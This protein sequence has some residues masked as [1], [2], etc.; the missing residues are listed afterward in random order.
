MSA[1]NLVLSIMGGLAGLAILG[2]GMWSLFRS[3]AQDDRIKRLQG[4]RDD[5]L[6]RLNFIEPR[7]RA[8]EQ[9]NELLLAMHN[10]TEKLD[11]LVATT[12]ETLTIV[13][14][15]RDIGRQIDREL[16]RPRGDQE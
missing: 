4:E 2:G 9:Q 1:I 11:G 5:Y 16:Y 10:P 15:M 7:H 13:R 3:S 14:A 6:S 8:I 12:D